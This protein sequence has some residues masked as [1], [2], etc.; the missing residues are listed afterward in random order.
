MEKITILWADDEIELLKPQLLFLEKKGYEVIQVTN[1]HDA[2]EECES[3]KAIDV[4]FL[5]ESMPGIT[6]LETLSR[7]KAV[8]PILPV[9]MITKNEAENV[10]EEALGSQIADYLIKPVNPNQIL[11]TLKKI[12]D[13]KRLVREK[14]SSDYQQEF[15]QIF[16]QINSGL[17]YEEWVEVY[18]KIINWEIKID[19]SNSTEMG[20]ILSMQKQEANTEFSKYILKNYL[21]WVQ[22]TKPGPVMSDNLLRSK[23]FPNMDN[24]VPSVLVLLDNLR[25]DQ[26]KVIEPILT[27]AF[28]LEEEDYFYSILPT[29]TQYSRNAIFSGM[30]PSD[31]DRAHPDWWRNDNEEGGKNLYEDQLFSELVR[32]TFRKELK[33]EYLKITSVSNARLMQ[34]NILNYLKN[35]LTIIVY[36]FI[37]MLSHARTEMEVLKELAGDEKAYRSLTRSWFENSPLWGALQRLA[38]REVQLFITTDHGT[39]RVNTPS[40]VVGDRETTTNLR[41]KVGRNLQYE[42]KDVLEVRDPL[43]AKLPRPNVSSSYI[44]AKE[45]VFFLYPNNYNYYNNYYKNTFQHGGISLEEMIC[46]FIRL[47]A[48]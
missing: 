39:I 1:G 28:R 31:I 41:Y 45:D 20:D 48:K 30:M 6:G 16:M 3:N 33:F 25:F 15:R 35:D 8:N 34:D 44:F 7:L 47:R 13:N 40:K 9:V 2:L 27:E 24:S 11:L 42:K 19:Q 26:W 46:P 21:D 4:V 29:S 12:I 43:Q 10:M 38:E 22:H 23:V 17:N 37:D 18:R 5:D 32:R 14:T 36:N